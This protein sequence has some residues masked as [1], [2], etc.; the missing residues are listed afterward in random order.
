MA[1]PNG[2]I[3][4]EAQLQLEKLQ[5]SQIVTQPDKTG[6]EVLSATA[7][8]YRVGD[9][10]SYRQTTVYGAVSHQLTKVTAVDENQVILNN[11]SAVLDTM[12]N[13][14]KD[15]A[16]TRNPPRINVPAD[17]K[18]GKQ[19]NTAYIIT[20]PSNNKITVAY[21]YKVVSIETIVTPAG[22]FMAFKIEGTAW[23]S[24]RARTEHTY[25]LDTKTLMLVKDRWKHAIGETTI[26]TAVYLNWFRSNGREILDNAG[27][28]SF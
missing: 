17:I 13:L 21:S 26:T 9:S 18:I 27:I 3:S 16:G 25:W 10:F 24:R 20:S 12:G 15:N 5:K 6:V 1:F 22:S 14:I 2:L 7:T 28:G 19:W 23:T 8:R 4:E 11:G